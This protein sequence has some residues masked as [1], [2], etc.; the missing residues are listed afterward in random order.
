MLN[1][2]SRIHSVLQPLQ[3][4]SYTNPI[5]IDPTD[6]YYQFT[7]S[8][9]QIGEGVFDFIKKVFK[10]RGKF[11]P[12][13]NEIASGEVSTKVKN[14]VGK[15]DNDPDARPLEVGEKH[16]PLRTGKNSLGWSNYMGPGTKLMK[17]LRRGDKPRTKADKVAKKHDCAYALSHDINDIR[18]ADNRMISKLKEIQQDG[19]DFTWNTQLGIKGI[20]TKQLGEDLGLMKRKRFLNPITDPEDRKLVQEEYDRL[21]QEGYGYMLPGQELKLQV[22]QQQKKGK[23]NPYTGTLFKGRGKKK[24]KMKKK[25]KKMKKKMKKKVRKMKKKV[26]RMKGGT[27]SAVE[28]IFQKIMPWILKELAKKGIKL[29]Q[30]GTG[31]LSLKKRIKSLLKQ[32]FGAGILSAAVPIATAALPIVWEIGKAVVPWIIKKIK[33]RRKGKQQGGFMTIPKAVKRKIISQ[34]AKTFTKVFKGIKKG[35]MRGMGIGDSIRTVVSTIASAIKKGVPIAKTAIKKGV[36]IIKK[37]APL[38]K[39]AIP[40]VKDIIKEVRKKEPTKTT[41]SKKMKPKKK[42]EK[43]KK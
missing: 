38:V 34:M 13:L 5:A 36:P 1:I 17:R 30:G 35:K 2:P 4:P 39:E 24:R 33:N 7:P 6:K 16:V 31:I 32:K 15:L 21:E 14:L 10:H 18:R 11:E 23:G 3:T 37:A 28:L 8:D 29:I 12:L 9:K 20:A 42:G 22:F 26:R 43:I 27:M 19:S 41:K 25:K 40:I